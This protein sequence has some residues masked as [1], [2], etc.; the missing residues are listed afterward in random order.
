MCQGAE[1]KLGQ[2]N[3]VGGWV[4]CGQTLG[5]V[6]ALME[7]SLPTTLSIELI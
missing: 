6:V 3:V 7:L 1:K 4:V 2:V 5:Q